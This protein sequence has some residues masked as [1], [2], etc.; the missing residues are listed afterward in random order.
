MADNKNTK[1]YIIKGKK[2]FANVPKLKADELIA[3]KN[4]ITLGYELVEEKVKKGITKKE[5]L[6]NLPDNSEVKA[7]FEKAYGIKAKEIKENNEEAIKT[8]VS[9]ARKYGIEPKTKKGKGDYVAG[10]H[11][12]CQIYAKWENENKTTTTTEE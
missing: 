4:Y 2:I 8:L 6:I 5:M 9:L 12:A 1:N 11:L 7:D 3:V 10:Y